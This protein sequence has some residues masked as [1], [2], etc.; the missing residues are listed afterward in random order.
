MI[1]GWAKGPQA[2]RGG[3]ADVGLLGLRHNLRLTEG[4]RG[5][6]MSSL[7]LD[8][9]IRKMPGGHLLAGVAYGKP[10][11]GIIPLLFSDRSSRHRLGGRC[12][13]REGVITP[14]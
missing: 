5:D 6:V 2:P 8:K 7:I 13:F 12:N 3:K 14:R 10:C 1:Q 4:E 9:T 11:K